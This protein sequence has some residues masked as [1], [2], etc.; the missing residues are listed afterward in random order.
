FRTGAVRFAEGVTTGDKGDGLFVIHRHAGEGLANITR[1]RY[2]VRIAVRALRVD[3]DQAHLD[4]A[5]IAVQFAIAGIAAVRT[6]AVREPRF[7]SAPVHMV[8]RLPSIGATAAETEHRTAHRL[9]GDVARENEEVGPRQLCAVLLL[10]RPKQAARLVEVAVIRPRVERRETLL[11]TT[12]AAT[13]VANA[14]GAGRVPGH[15]DEER[16]IVPVIC[17]P[18]RL[19]VRHQRAEIGNHRIKIEAFE[20]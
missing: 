9:D 16:T 14:I 10:D 7:F 15:A 13:A 20:F 18:P 1:G 2:G 11:T 12:A 3:V 19:R 8:L 4:G 5:Q 17:R 6:F